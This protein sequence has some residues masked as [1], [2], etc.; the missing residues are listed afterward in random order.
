LQVSLSTQVAGIA[1]HNNLTLNSI[2]STHTPLF[3][4]VIVPSHPFDFLSLRRFLYCGLTNGSVVRITINN[5]NFSASA[6]TL[7]S[8][9][10][11]NQSLTQIQV[12]T[13]R[14]LIYAATQGSGPNN[15]AIVVRINGSTFT[16]VRISSLQHT[17][18]Y[19]QK[20][21]IHS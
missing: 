5:L 18:T 2:K 15:Q 9:S 11:T 17:H 16:E 20:V 3:C 19:I 4:G 14:N 8:T 7:I 13:Y 6:M 12:D 10:A 1:H 21:H